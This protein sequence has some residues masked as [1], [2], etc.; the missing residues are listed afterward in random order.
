MIEKS[1]LVFDI[2]AGKEVETFLL[3]ALG[4]KLMAACRS[5]KVDAVN[6]LLTCSPSDV[7]RIASLQAKVESAAF[8]D[9]F[10][11]QCVEDASLATQRLEFE[12]DDISF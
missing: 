5:R 4:R 12:K 1:K 10:F 2:E 3:S 11:E 7:G 8:V 6:E 9:S